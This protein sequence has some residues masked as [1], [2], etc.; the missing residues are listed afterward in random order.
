MAN[1]SRRRGQSNKL[2]PR[3]VRLCLV[4]EALPNHTYKI[5][6]SGQVSIQNEAH[7][8][9]HWANPDAVREAP[10]LLEPSTQT[11][12]LDRVQHRPEYEVFV[13]QTRD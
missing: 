3:F 1:Y 4:V 6:R 7:L 9:L 12:M 8:K 11:A 13:Q 2:Q 10:L 5:E